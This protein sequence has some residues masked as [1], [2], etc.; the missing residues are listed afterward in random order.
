MTDE[1]SSKT[2]AH[3][4]REL[5]EG[6]VRDAAQFG[7]EDAAKAAEVYGVEGEGAEDAKFDRMRAAIAKRLVHEFHLTPA[8][9]VDF[10]AIMG[11]AGYA[12]L[13]AEV[14]KVAADAAEDARRYEAQAE[15]A[16]VMITFTR[17]LFDITLHEEGDSATTDDGCYNRLL[18]VIQTHKV[19]LLVVLPEPAR[20]KVASLASCWDDFAEDRERARSDWDEEDVQQEYEEAVR[21]EACSLARWMFESGERPAVPVAPY[22][23]PP[24]PVYFHATAPK[25]G[26][27]SV[28]VEGKGPNGDCNTSRELAQREAAQRNAAFAKRTAPVQAFLP[29]AHPA[30]TAGAYLAAVASRPT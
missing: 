24:P 13:Q 11:D 23:A 2:W 3:V 22:V 30:A 18:K 26:E 8:T 27:P 28:V 10:K 7:R 9:V 15:A 21:D 29:H 12:V 6:V 17:A 14:A 16:R 5:M 20:K 4:G 19:T 1:T 25:L